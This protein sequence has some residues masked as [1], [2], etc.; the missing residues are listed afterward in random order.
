MLKKEESLVDGKHFGPPHCVPRKPIFGKYSFISQ[1]FELL[2][3]VRTATPPFLPLVSPYFDLT[4]QFS[5]VVADLTKI[6][7]DTDI[8]KR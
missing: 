7:T 8:L 4:L 5:L 3:S 1:I 6:H 2:K